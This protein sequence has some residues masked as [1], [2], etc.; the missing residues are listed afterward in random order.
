MVFTPF[1]LVVEI[2]IR[3][4]VNSIARFKLVSKRWCSSISNPHFIASQLEHAKR[5][6]DQCLLLSCTTQE[7]LQ[8]YSVKD[9]ALANFEYSAP[10][11]DDS[12]HVMPSCNGLVCFYGINFGGINVCNPIT[13]N[14]IKLPS[15]DSMLEC[16]LSCGFGF[17]EVN[18]EFKVIKMSRRKQ[19]V[20]G[21]DDDLKFEIHTLGSQSWRNVQSK[22]SATLQNRKPPVFA[23]GFF[24]WLTANSSVPGCFSIV[25]FD[26]DK[27]VFGVVDPPGDLLRKKWFVSCLE[28][29]GG[30]LCF[31][32]LDFESKR[33]MDIWVFR[34][35]DLGWSQESIVHESEPLD[36]ARPVAINGR[37]VLLLG[38]QG[39]KYC[40]SWY[41]LKS[42]SFRPLEI[43][44]TPPPTFFIASSHVESLGVPWFTGNGEA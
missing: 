17:S 28:V 2:L 29:L 4:P 36:L 3:L 7:N 13:K 1:D 16:L 38:F 5:K 37:E 20:I 12:Y 26:I 40:L 31:V 14:L 10:S 9:G 34:G 6:K 11:I 22:P 27:E 44:G 15:S 43:K 19:T 24:Y 18:H 42:R 39:L 41:N 35:N 33:R 25:S 32:D 8:F 23:N 30:N 21:N